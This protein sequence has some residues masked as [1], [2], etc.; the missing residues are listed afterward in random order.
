MAEKKKQTGQASRNNNKSPSDVNGTDAQAAAIVAEQKKEA[1]PTPPEQLPLS[2]PNNPVNM[3]QNEVGMTPRDQLPLSHPDNP[4]NMSAGEKGMTPWVP[5]TQSKNTLRGSTNLNN[6]SSGLTDGRYI[7]PFT[8][9]DENAISKWNNINPNEFNSASGYQAWNQ[10]NSAVAP[11]GA[12]ARRNKMRGG[13]S[14][15]DYA[16]TPREIGPNGESMVRVFNGGQSYLVPAQPKKYDGAGGGE[17]GS[18]NVL[19]GFGASARAQM[20]R[21][22]AADMARAQRQAVVNARRNANVQNYRTKAENERYRRALSMM[23]QNDR[24]NTSS[25]MGDLAYRDFI[26]ERNM[27]NINAGKRAPTSTPGAYGGPGSDRALKIDIDR[28]AQNPYMSPRHR[29]DMVQKVVESYS[30]Q[31]ENG[32]RTPVNVQSYNVPRV[33]TSVPQDTYES[34]MPEI[35]GRGAMDSFNNLMSLET[36]WDRDILGG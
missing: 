11:L 28:Y 15:N 16:D 29:K 5:A 3:S 25:R 20:A 22:D 34:P 24:I 33:S 14:Q 32:L 7:G 23:S 13:L 17:N 27:A 1:P 6:N 30:S 35:P 8:A 18:P 9:A 19:E 36:N 4:V 2:N 26:H 31:A 12:L 10:A 21:N